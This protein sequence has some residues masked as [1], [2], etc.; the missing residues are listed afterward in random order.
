MQDQRL[1]YVEQHA[2]RIGVDASRLENL[3]V[4]A[5]KGSIMGDTLDV[6]ARQVDV[7]SLDAVVPVLSQLVKRGVGL[8]TQAGAARFITSLATRMGTDLR[9]QSGALLKVALPCETK[10]TSLYRDVDCSC[11]CCHHGG[12]FCPLLSGHAHQHATSVLIRGYDIDEETCLHCNAGAYVCSTYSQQSY[13]ETLLRSGNGGCG[14]DSLRDPRR[15]VSG[16]R[17]PVVL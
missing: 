4:S 13:S 14:K 15:Q 8:N 11:M 17:S 12:I 5:A 1:N 16:R 2:E 7:K 10:L 9:P 3:R 6:C